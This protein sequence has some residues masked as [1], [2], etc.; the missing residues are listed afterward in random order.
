MVHTV[1]LFKFLIINMKDI[2]PWNF[3]NNSNPLEPDQ[4]EE[5]TIINNI[6]L[7]QFKHCVKEQVWCT[8]YYHVNLK[9]TLTHQTD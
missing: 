5:Y 1:N 6:N 4:K 7:L 9:P 2:Y 8:R 3:L